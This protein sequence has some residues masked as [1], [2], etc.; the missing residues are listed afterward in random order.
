MLFCY[1]S[2]GFAKLFINFAPMLTLDILICTIGQRIRRVPQMLLAPRTDVKY[3]V[4]WQTDMTTPDDFMWMASA[5]ST[6]P[7]VQVFTMDG[8]GLSRN[9]N[10]ALLHSTSSI[11]LIADDDCHYTDECIDRILSTY[12][13]NTI[14]DIICFMAADSDGHPIKRYP[15]SS[16]AYSAAMQTGYYPSSVELTFRRD[17]IG[18]LK[19]NERFGLGSGCFI[20]GEESIFL[21]DASERHLNI[22]FKNQTVVQTDAATTGTRCPTDPD[23]LAAKGAVFAYC[24]PLHQAIWMCLKEAVHHARFNHVNPFTVFHNMMYGVKRSHTNI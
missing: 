1:Q 24:Y 7:D 3:I 4:S 6:R 20:S 9:R 16:M 11:C 15:V 22:L 21:H 12:Q 19:F 23:V 10:N 2:S 18:D 13:S 17:R 8:A 14:D 5:F